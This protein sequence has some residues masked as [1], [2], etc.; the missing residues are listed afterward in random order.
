MILGERSQD[1]MNEWVCTHKRRSSHLIYIVI[2]VFLIIYGGN[3]ITCY[4]NEM[5]L[6]AH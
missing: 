1:Y 2:H 6:L 4:K 5:I 3:E